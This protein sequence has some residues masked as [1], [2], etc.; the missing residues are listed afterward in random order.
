MLTTNRGSLIEP[1]WF[2]LDESRGI[3][4]QLLKVYMRATVIV[5]EYLVYI[6]AVVVFIRRYA[7]DQRVNVWTA[8]VAL[9]AILLQPATI[10][11][12]HGHFQYNTVML[13]LVV[14][15]MESIMAKRMLWACVFFVAALG[16]K[17]MALYYAPVVFA[18]MLGSCFSPRVRLGRLFGI[19]LITIMSFALLFAPLIGGAIYES[20]RGIPIPLSQ[21]PL[22]QRLPISLNETSWLYAPIL[23]LSQSIHRIF[24]FARGLFEDK[25][26]NLWCT[27][28]TFYKLSRFPSSALQRASLGA[29]VLS[30]LVPC[31]TIGWHPRPELLLLALANTAWGFFLCS[32]QVHEKSVL[33]PL[34]PMTLLL[35]GDGNLGKDSRAWVGLANILGAWTLFPLLKRE[36]LRVPYYVIVLLWA[37]LLGLPPTSLDLYRNQQEPSDSSSRSTN[38]HFLTKLVHLG[39]Y[40]CII[41]W[42]LLEGFVPP[43]P[44]KPDLWV[45]LNVL[46]GTAGFGIMYLWCMVKLIQEVRLLTGGP[47]LH[48]HQVTDRKKTQ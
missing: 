16:F 24:P 45:V 8:S 44:T 5:S 26:A 6:P 9:I 36:E 10:L 46:I 18:Y 2:A 40:F 32:F 23:Q 34:L 28:H 41:S 31:I 7:R 37:Y 12:D 27:A 20:Y 42:H 38:L 1:S 43:P 14:A 39:C 33:L 25:V 21:P 47:K 22:F 30:I 3:E 17:Q 15:T 35:C 48:W 29:T 11:I 19:S 4:D 13:G